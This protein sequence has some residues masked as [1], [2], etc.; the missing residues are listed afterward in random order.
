MPFARVRDLHTYYELAGAGPRVLFINGS[1]GDL[2]R[3]PS[4][5]ASPLAAAFTL[6]AHDQR[7]LGQTTVPDPP[8]TMSD[9]ADDAAALLDAIGWD[10][11]HVVGT[12]FGGMVAQEFALRHPG[13][14]DRLV[15]NCTSSGGDGGSSYPLHEFIGLS[16]EARFDATMPISDV[17]RDDDWQATHPEEVDTLRAQFLTA[18]AIGAGEPRRAIGAAAQLQARIDHNVYDRL[19]RLTMPVLVCGGRSDGIAPP[20]NLQAI[21]AQIPQAELAL[22]NGGHLFFIQ[23]RTAY[24]R[25]IDFLLCGMPT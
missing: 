25:M 2:R 6:L 16:L 5:F 7:G 22:F 14:V 11:C 10:R 17:R 13:R 12:S 9:Y 3:Q 1:G 20:A 19:P 8:Y 23:D 21:A 15:L 18:Q 4:V 24:P